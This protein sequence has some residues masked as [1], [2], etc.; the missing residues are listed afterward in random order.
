MSYVPQRTWIQPAP[1]GLGQ[2]PDFCA[3]DF[4]GPL[5]P[6]QQLT[7]NLEAGIAYRDALLAQQGAGTTGTFGAW[8][9]A[10]QKT[11]LWVGAGL[12]GLALLKG[13]RS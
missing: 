5:T 9:Q 6:D 10:N 1:R 12:F 2:A 4:V 11:V 8:L 7:C 13:M 3:P